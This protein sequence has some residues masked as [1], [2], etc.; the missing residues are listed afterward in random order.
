M[1]TR[2]VRRRILRDIRVEVSQEFDRNFEREAFFGEAWRRRRGP[3][4]GGGHLLVSTG[5]LR[6][7]VMSRSDETSVTF[8]SSLPY[9]AIHNNGGRIRVTRRMRAFFWAKHREAVGG[10]GRRRDG[11]LSRSRRQARL[12]AEAE[13]WRAMA[14]KRVGDE[15]VIP[16]RRFLGASPELESGVRRIIDR[17]LEEYLGAALPEELRK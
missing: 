9:A 6:R 16:R 15:I 8:Y 13:F 11:S 12:S 2:E 7:S 4:R 17:N 1:D 3:V 14:L 5:A 10:F